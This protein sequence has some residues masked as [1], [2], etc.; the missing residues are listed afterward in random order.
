LLYSVQNIILFFEDIM[1]T[2]STDVSA[3]ALGV[4]RKV[5]D[6]VLAREGRSLLPIGVRGR[7]RRVSTD[8]LERIAV[9]LILN[10][11]L[12]VSIAKGLELAERISGSPALPIAVG[13]MSALAFDLPRL[14]DALEFSVNE[15]LECVA[16]RTR[17]RPGVRNTAGRLA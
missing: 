14:R 5:L 16:E 15:A 1:R 9:A 11:D 7:R 17:G 3:A 2:L 12:G 10:R 8:T 13:A 6:N 4:D